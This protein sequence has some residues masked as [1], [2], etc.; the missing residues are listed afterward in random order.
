MIAKRNHTLF[1]TW[2]GMMYRCYKPY[3]SH[4]K[5]YGAKGVTVCDRWHDFWNFVEDIDNHMENGYLLYH[6]SYQLDKD[7]NGGMIYSLGN[8]KVI[9]AEENNKLHHDK[10]Q[11]KVL[12]FN[13]NEKMEFNSLAET[14]KILNIPR[15]SIITSIKRNSRHKSGY[16]FKYVS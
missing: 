6:K 4:Y 1:S 7:K 5:Y 12:A 2:A 8:C 14:G 15:S 16:Y 13:D 10:Q 9:T 3:H 11:R